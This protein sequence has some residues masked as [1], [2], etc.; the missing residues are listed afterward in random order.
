MEFLP[1]VPDSPHT[2]T[3]LGRCLHSPASWKVQMFWGLRPWFI[4]S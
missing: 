4:P 1:E 2:T 3:L